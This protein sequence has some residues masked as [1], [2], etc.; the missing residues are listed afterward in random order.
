MKSDKPLNNSG[1]TH[2][3]RIKKPGQSWIVLRDQAIKDGKWE[4][5][6][7]PKE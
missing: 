4:K 2:F 5:P 1:K 6:K 3:N 7:L